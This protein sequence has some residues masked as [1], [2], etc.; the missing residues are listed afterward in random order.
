MKP[1]KLIIPTV[2]AVSLLAGCGEGAD[3]GGPPESVS[4]Q[5]SQPSDQPAGAGSPV[6]KKQIDGTALP[7]QY[8][9]EVQS[10]GKKVTIT[11]MESSACEKATA[12]VDKQT[13]SQVVITLEHR[14][15]GNNQMCAQMVKYPKLAVDLDEP[16][17]DREL[18]LKAEKT[19]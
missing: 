19:K 15:A 11:A 4:T 9:Q 1:L 2:A 3:A 5:P 14:N 8:P 17:E 16:L 12:K 18:V 10:S 7:K 6:A 13:D